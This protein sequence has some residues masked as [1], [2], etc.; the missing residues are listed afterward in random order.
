MAKEIIVRIKGDNVETKVGQ[1]TDN[2]TKANAVMPTTEAKSS[3]AKSQALALSG[4]VIQQAMQ[5]SMSNV[6]KMEW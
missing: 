6:G 5:Y 3:E 4:M 2:S 1:P